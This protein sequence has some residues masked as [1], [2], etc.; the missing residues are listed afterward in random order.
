[1]AHDQNISMAE[2]KSIEDLYE[3]VLK[4][5]EED[6]H[7]ADMTAIDVLIRHCPANDLIHYLP[8]GEWK[9]FKHLIENND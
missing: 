5:I 7:C 2:K 3:M 4:Q 8:D 1:M 6:V 9:K